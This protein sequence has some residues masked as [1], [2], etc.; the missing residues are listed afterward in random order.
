MKFNDG[1]TRGSGA[2]TVSPRSS[3]TAK[4]WITA[5]CVGSECARDCDNPELCEMLHEWIV[6]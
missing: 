2:T 5:P 3:A 6:S 4:L 1:M